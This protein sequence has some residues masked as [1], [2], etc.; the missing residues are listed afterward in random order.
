MQEK[1][2]WTIGHSTHPFDEFIDILKSFETQLLID[3]RGYPGSRRH[4]HFNKE[5]LQLTLPENGIEYLHISGLGGRRKT[6]PDS[7]NTGWRLDAFRGY[8]DYMETDDFN[9]AIMELQQ[10]AIEKRSAYM[11]AEILW[12]RCHRSLVSDYLKWSGW[13]VIHIMGKGKGAEHYFR[14]PARIVDG[15][16]SYSKE[17]NVGSE[18]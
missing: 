2:V 15:R 13:K 7:R 9:T 12:W 11:C 4:P 14:E 16:L 17:Q 10:K 1:T 6:K 8:A 18:L 5:S 3:I